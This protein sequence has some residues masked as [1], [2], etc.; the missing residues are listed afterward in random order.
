VGANFHYAA[1]SYLDEYLSVD[2]DC[3]S[4]L[5]DEGRSDEQV[6]EAL[7]R[8]ATYYRIIRNLSSKRCNETYRLSPVLEELRKIEPPISGTDAVEAVNKLVK[9][10]RG[11]YQ[12]ELTSAA[13]KILWMRYQSPLVIYDSLAHGALK[14]LEQLKDSAG[15]PDYFASWHRAYQS[16]VS[17]VSSAC[18]ELV[19]IKQFTLATEMNDQELRDLVERVW[20]QERVFDHW[21]VSQGSDGR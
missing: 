14:K 1:Y 11:R 16:V 12:Q 5:S 7:T 6:C 3:M 15:Y 8:M 20:F 4:V 18:R 10:L 9:A 19:G 2:R 13:S 21:L 17:G